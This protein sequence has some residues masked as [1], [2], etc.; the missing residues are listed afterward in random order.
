MK[1]KLI[2]QGAEAKI[3]LQ[4]NIITKERIPKAYRH[5]DLDLK[6]RKSRT[7]REAKLL[8]K[9]NGLGINTPK[10]LN[11][12]MFSLKIE[13]LDGEKLSDTL[14]SYDL[15]MQLEVIKKL[16]KETSKLHINEIIHGDLT[17]SNV[18]LLDNKTY[19]ID[20][21]LGKISHK[22]EDK[23]VDLHLIKEAI[24]AKH[25]KNSKELFQS[26]LEGY[27]SNESNDIIKRLE[28]VEKRGRYKR[29]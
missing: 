20:F 5:Q 9:A 14:N 15:K 18:I 29:H 27:E 25:F 4:D 26:F 13:Y 1:P 11:S 2:F 3:Y 12:E 28:V 23:A 8:T 19:I 7:K 10:I 17:T 24:N 16:G 21:G 22:I 6:L